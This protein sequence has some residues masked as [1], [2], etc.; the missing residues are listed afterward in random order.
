MND[1]TIQLV[2]ESFDLVE[3]MAPQAA[4]LFRENLVQAAPTLQTLLHS[5]AGAPGEQLVLAMGEA[6]RQ[7]REPDDLLP[8]VEGLGRRHAGL[9][10]LRDEDYDAV[11]GA[12]LKTLEQ[13]L[14]PAFDDETRAAW[15]DVYSA[16]AGAMKQVSRSASAA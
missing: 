15:I 16:M 5:D 1:Y 9:M 4:A 7:L 13:G 2:N 3:P 10:G 11:G 12:L 14:G 6:L 8:A